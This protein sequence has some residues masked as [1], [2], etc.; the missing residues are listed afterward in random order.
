MPRKPK[1]YSRE[2][3]YDMIKRTP[4]IRDKAL[5]AITYLTAARIGEVLKLRKKDLRD[6]DDPDILVVKLMTEK[7]R[8]EVPRLIPIYK[9]DPLYVYIERYLK[10]LPGENPRLFPITRQRAWQ[11]MKYSGINPH[12]LRHSRLTEIAPYLPTQTHLFIFAGW[13]IPGP[14]ETY[15]HL[16]YK[17]LIPYVKKVVE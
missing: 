17:S 5:I 7:R 2:Q 9:K 14:A 10:T 1:S 15:I 4:S 12:S 6:D 13:K 11:I 8:R 16:N 3:I